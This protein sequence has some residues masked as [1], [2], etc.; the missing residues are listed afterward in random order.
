[1]NPS[2]DEPRAEDYQRA[3][4]VFE[5]SA[6]YVGREQVDQAAASGADKILR[7]EKSVPKALGE[8][9]EELKLMVGLMADYVTGRYREAPT[10]TISAVAA[11]VL[12]FVSPIDVIPDFI[13]VVGYLDDA[14]VIRY[15]L[16]LIGQDLG[17]YKAWKEGRL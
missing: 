1:M 6:E 14:V 2:P 15:C 9:W 17:I 8:M 11:A 12:Y 3:K 10:K 5:E 7:L 16:K 13:P 4:H